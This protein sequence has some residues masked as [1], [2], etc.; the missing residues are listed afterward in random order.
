MVRIDSARR[1]LELGRIR[2]EP[3]RRLSTLQKAHTLGASQPNLLIWLARAA[4]EAGDAVASKQ[5]TSC[6]RR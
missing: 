3:A 6:S 4:I 2:P 1:R 5:R